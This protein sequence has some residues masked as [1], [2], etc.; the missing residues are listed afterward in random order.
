MSGLHRLPRSQH[1]LIVVGCFAE[2]HHGLVWEVSWV[3]P[4]PADALAFGVVNVPKIIERPGLPDLSGDKQPSQHFIG[5]ATT[6]E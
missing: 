4:V 5:Y 3:G 6:N 1:L 2:S